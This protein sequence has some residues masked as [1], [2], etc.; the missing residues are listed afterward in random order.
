[1]KADELLMR[2]AY[3]YNTL[4]MPLNGSAEN[5][6]NIDARFMQQFMMDNITPR[7]CTIV[8][9]GVQN[10]EEFV[11]MVKERLGDMLSVPED[12][13]QREKAVYIGGETHE[14]VESPETCIKLAFE[15]C[16]WT[17]D[18]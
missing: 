10:H 15:S 2:T 17:D 5:I 18:D 14:F 4:G 8:G 3:G 6:Q 16:S 12:R 9:S 7:K 11:E 13:Y 1:M